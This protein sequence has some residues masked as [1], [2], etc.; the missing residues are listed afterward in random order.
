[1]RPRKANQ[2][3][4]AKSFDNYGITLKAN[5]DGALCILTD[6]NKLRTQSGSMTFDDAWGVLRRIEEAVEE[7]FADAIAGLTEAA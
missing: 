5:A 1:M 4:L 7:A 3:L 6:R 2:K